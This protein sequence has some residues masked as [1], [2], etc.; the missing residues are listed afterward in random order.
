MLG[1]GLVQ[2]SPCSSESRSQCWD[3]AAGTRV[4]YS[5]SKQNLVNGS[6]EDQQD[7]FSVNCRLVA[8]R[9]SRKETFALPGFLGP[10]FTGRR[11]PVP[12]TIRGEEPAER[13][14]LEG[15]WSGR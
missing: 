11:F 14:T 6:A 10:K 9:L 2:Q 12:N 15:T 3:E 4:E 8:A 13:D 5:N 1:L 7:G